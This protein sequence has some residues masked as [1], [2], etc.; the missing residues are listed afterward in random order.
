MNNGNIQEKSAVLKVLTSL[1]L[2]IKKKIR[3]V[4]FTNNK[5]DLSLSLSLS[6]SFSLLSLSISFSLSLSRAMWR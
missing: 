5:N 1:L 3:Y 4:S 2:F 6:L